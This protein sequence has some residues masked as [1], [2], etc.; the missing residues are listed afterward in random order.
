MLQTQQT[1]IQNDSQS[2]KAALPADF[3]WGKPPSY[4]NKRP[5]YSQVHAVFLSGDRLTFQG[6]HD[7]LQHKSDVKF[8]KTQRAKRMQRKCCARRIFST[9][10]L[11]YP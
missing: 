2:L 6:G 4:H 9:S 3:S 11:Q 10:P 8:H 5:T 1:W 7:N